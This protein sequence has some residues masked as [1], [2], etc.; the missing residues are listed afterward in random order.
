MSQPSSRAAS[1][2]IIQLPA[3]A[4]ELMAEARDA[5][6]GRAARTLSSSTRPQFKQTLVA[7]EE[8]VELSEHTGPA[9]ATVHV[10]R[11]KICLVSD[12]DHVE[13]DAGDHTVMPTEA[14]TVRCLDDAVALLSVAA[15]PS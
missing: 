6:A 11:G 8:G 14:H 13:L 15:Q 3:L 12:D 9:A 5:R 1:A 7:L 10:L 4:D 2:D